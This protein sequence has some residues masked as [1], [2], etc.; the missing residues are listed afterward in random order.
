MGFNSKLLSCMVSIELQ[1][2]FPSNTAALSA[3]PLHPREV[4]PACLLHCIERIMSA[5]SPQ[6]YAVVCCCAALPAAGLHPRGALPACLLHCTERCT[7]ALLPQR[8][9][10]CLMLCCIASCTFASSWGAGIVHCKR[11][12]PPHLNASMQV[13]LWRHCGF[14]I[15]KQ[16]CCTLW[17]QHQ[18]PRC[19]IPK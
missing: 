9:V 2:D 10:R 18:A 12:A 16:L 6:L 14:V 17:L 15:G 3:A 4:L 11:L 1:G 5:P 7:S 13:R 8:R 19:T